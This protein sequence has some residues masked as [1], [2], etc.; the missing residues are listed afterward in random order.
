MSDHDHIKELNRALSR[1]GC[2]P[3][4]ALDGLGPAG[5]IPGDVYFAVREDLISKYPWQF[6]LQFSALTRVSDGENGWKSSF[7]LPPDRLGLPRAFYANANDRETVRR[8][9]YEGG[10]ILTNTDRL[11]CE[12]Q[13]NPP[14]EDCPPY[15]LEL[16]RLAAGA[17]LAFA[18]REDKQTRRD[19]RLS[20]YGSEQYQGEGGQ[21]GVAKNLDAQAAPTQSAPTGG[22]ELAILRGSTF[23]DFFE[24]RY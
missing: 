4:N 10:Q 24:G 14:V 12:Y 6:S 18:I 8:F 13:R 1:V 20:A 3:V 7:R 19:F 9:Q 5:Q 17:E 21:F 11:F 23:N 15:F 22:D 2:K 16:V